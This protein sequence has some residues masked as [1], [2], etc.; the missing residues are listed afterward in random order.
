MR[1]A[2]IYCF[3]QGQYQFVIAEVNLRFLSNDA[4]AKTAYENAIEADFEAR[5]MGSSENFLA[6]PAVN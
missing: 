3:H 2:P 1:A 6:T 5:K 4:A